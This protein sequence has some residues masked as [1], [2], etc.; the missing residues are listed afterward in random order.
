MTLLAVLAPHCAPTEL[1]RPWSLRPMIRALARVDAGRHVCGKHKPLA[2]TGDGRQCHA[3]V[4]NGVKRRLREL[5]HKHDDSGELAVAWVV[6]VPL[7][8]GYSGN[9]SPPLATFR[10]TAWILTFVA[11]LTFTSWVKTLCARQHRARRAMRRKQILAIPPGIT[12]V[13]PCLARRSRHGQARSTTVSRVT[14]P[15]RA[16]NI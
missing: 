2:R 4:A 9:R 11:S 7:G 16:V 5:W 15:K 3:R 14:A 6:V 8:C 12:A 13:C 10:K 1:G